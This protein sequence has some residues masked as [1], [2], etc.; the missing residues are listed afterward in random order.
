QM[1][2]EPQ[3]RASFARA[4]AMFRSCSSPSITQGPAMNARGAPSPTARSRAISTRRVRSGPRSALGLPELPAGTDKAPEERMGE[5]R[6]RFE[7]GMELTGQ[8][9]RMVRDLHDLHEAAIGRL[10]AHAQTLPQHGVE[11]LPVHLV[12][13]PVALADLR[14]A[15][16][17]M[18]LR[19][20]LEDARP[21]P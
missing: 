11:I 17:A 3:S 6:L 1:Y 5:H 21:L 13:V 12:A 18:C 7:F 10:A 15:V 20:R 2:G 19:S 9:V 4:R 8:E 16:G 14:P